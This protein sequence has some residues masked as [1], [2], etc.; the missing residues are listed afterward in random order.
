M[1]KGG[2][3]ALGGGEIDFTMATKRKWWGG[4]EQGMEGSGG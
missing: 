1:E 3:N 4:P 2:R